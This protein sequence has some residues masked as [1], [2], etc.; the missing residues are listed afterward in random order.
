M[1][2]QFELIRSLATDCPSFSKRDGFVA[3]GGLIEKLSDLKLKGP[4]FDTLL[5]IS[6]AVGPQ[7]VCSEMHK[8]AVVHKNPKVCGQRLGYFL[9]FR[10]SQVRA[11]VT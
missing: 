3:L 6:E 9:G 10:V 2:R 11:F 4:S 8:K 5:A 7:F 1:A